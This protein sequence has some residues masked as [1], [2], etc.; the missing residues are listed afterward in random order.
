M[1]TRH[2][3][4]PAHLFVDNSPYFITGTIYKKRPLLESDTVKDYLLATIKQCFEEKSWLLNDWVI[5]NNHYHLLV[6][7]KSGA[8]LSNIM[9]KI[10]MLS[11]KF[12]CSGLHAEK[13]IWW[14]FWDYCPRDEKDYLV[15]LNYLLNNP[16]KHGYVTDLNDYRYSS[17]HNILKN[18][19]RAFLAKQFREYSDYK[20]LVLDEDSE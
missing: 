4:S 9:G 15:R 17:F 14:N 1:L 2:T 3:N 18:Q 16:V 13:P 5:L 6:T 7:S 10:H 8:D 20:N 12:I 19:S 11:A